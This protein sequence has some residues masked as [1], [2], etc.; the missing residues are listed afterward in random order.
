M[1]ASK[2]RVV[3]DK[4][5]REITKPNYQRHYVSC[6]TK[7]TSQF[8]CDTWY[9]GH[10][11]VCPSCNFATATRQS[12]TSHYWRH[13]TD[14]HIKFNPAS[15]LNGRHKSWNR[16]KTKDTDPRV[17]KNAENL[18]LSVKGRPGPKPTEEHKRNTSIRMSLNNPGGK[19]KWYE[20]AGQKVQGT[21]ERDIALKLEELGIK[22]YKAKVNKDVWS[23]TLDGKIRSYTPDIHLVD[24][25]IYLEIK[26]YWWGNDRAKMDAV[27]SQH[28]DKK[29]LII[30]K[31]EYQKIL[32]GEL[33]W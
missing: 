2:Q 9:D 22:W 24:L 30:E 8:S 6:G 28:P 7:K 12:M 15:K 10:Q 26:G 31:E 3:C 20:V 4:C 1:H 29:L 14:P 27:I 16:G 33:V 23:Y 11:W 32:G 13:H 19:S 5:T 25:D 21:W 18:A 17:A